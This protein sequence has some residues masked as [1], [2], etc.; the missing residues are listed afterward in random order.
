MT[1]LAMNGWKWASSILGLKRLISPPRNEP[2]NLNE[3]EYIVPRVGVSGLST[4]DR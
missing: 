4:V 1:W 3:R 2:A